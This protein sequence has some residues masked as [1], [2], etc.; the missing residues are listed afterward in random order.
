M[1]PG[2]N[3]KLETP[4]P[5]KSLKLSNLDHGEHLGGWVTIQGL[6]MAAV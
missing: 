2:Y 3:T 5:V 6:A 1:A 4:V